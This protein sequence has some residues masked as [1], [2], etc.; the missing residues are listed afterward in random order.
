ME[1]PINRSITTTEWTPVSLGSGQKCSAYAVWAR[2]EGVTFMMKK[3]LS[4]DNYLTVR[5]GMV[6]AP[7]YQHGNPGATLFY[8]K[9]VTSD[10]TLE[11]LVLNN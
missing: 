11:V 7:A 4:S 5:S 1:E 6:P 10:T 2:D 9:A 3:T 8:A